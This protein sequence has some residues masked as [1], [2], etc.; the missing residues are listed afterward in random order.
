MNEHGPM[1]S[2]SQNWKK[3][4][5]LLSKVGKEL[6]SL[7]AEIL[8]EPLRRDPRDFFECAWFFEEVRRPGHYHELFLCAQC[9]VRLTIEGN[10]LVIFPT[11]DQQ[12]GRLYLSQRRHGQI[13]TSPAG[14]D[15][16]DLFAKSGGR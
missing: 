5:F 8:G 9:G 10:D 12:R 6:V 14:D 16:T 13:G 1:C 2:F 4:R 11:D 7:G 15:C 3:Y